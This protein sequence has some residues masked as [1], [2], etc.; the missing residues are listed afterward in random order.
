MGR[1]LIY[2]DSEMV[3]KKQKAQAQT[4]KKERRYQAPVIK[5]EQIT[6]NFYNQNIMILQPN[7]I[8]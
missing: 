4:V 7:Q 2:K 3:S 6:Q 1:N 5:N 8:D